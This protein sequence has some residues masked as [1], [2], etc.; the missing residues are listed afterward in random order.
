MDD[1]YCYHYYYY[2]YHHQHHKHQHQLIIN[3]LAPTRGHERGAHVRLPGPTAKRNPSRLKWA[4][5][6]D[7]VKRL[8]ANDHDEMASSSQ[9]E[10]EAK[11]KIIPEGRTISTRSQTTTVL[12]NRI[13]GPVESSKASPPSNEARQRRGDKLGL[14][15]EHNSPLAARAEPKRMMRLIRSAPSQLWLA[16]DEL[17]LLRL[18]TGTG[19]WPRDDEPESFGAPLGPLLAV[20]WGKSIPASLLFSLEAAENND[21]PLGALETGDDAAQDPRSGREWAWGAAR[22]HSKQDHYRTHPRDALAHSLHGVA[23]YGVTLDDGVLEPGHGDD[24]DDNRSGELE[25]L[26][27]YSEASEIIRSSGDGEGADKWAAARAARAREALKKEPMSIEDIGSGKHERAL[28]AARG[29]APS[30]LASL[31]LM[32]SILVA[33]QDPGSSA[34]SADLQPR[35]PAP[36]SSSAVATGGGWALPL[37]AN[38]VV[39]SDWRAPKDKPPEGELKFVDINERPQPAPDASSNGTTTGKSSGAT[40]PLSTRGSGES[41]TSASGALAAARS[42]SSAMLRHLEHYGDRRYGQWA[43]RRFGGAFRPES[44]APSNDNSNNHH[45]SRRRAFDDRFGNEMGA[46]ANN[47]LAT[48]TGARPARS[49]TL[50]RFPSWLRLVPGSIWNSIAGGGTVSADRHFQQQLQLQLAGGSTPA[51]RRQVALLGGGGGATTNSLFDR[52]RRRIGA[53]NSIRVHNAFR[54]FAWRLLASLSMPTPII[55]E[56][57]RQ[58]FYSPDD[59]LANDGLF[60][61][62]TSKTLRIGRTLYTSIFNN[63]N[64]NINNSFRNSSIFKVPSNDNNKRNNNTTTGTGRSGT[65]LAA[66]ALMPLVELFLLGYGP[67]HTN[68]A[69]KYLMATSSR[70]SPRALTATMGPNDVNNQMSSATNENRRYFYAADDDDDEERLVEKLI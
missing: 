51:R 27:F 32:M 39:S 67:N 6:V 5:V 48:A 40:S 11:T 34:A 26:A 8:P 55:Y 23:N 42:L 65:E 3:N 68:D 61:K 52:I 20:G 24:D 62:N 47:E 70:R 59:D 25:A 37:G 21:A 35:V 22:S 43:E 12:W 9:R 66:R 13:S 60:N 14:I 7:V 53:R 33:I 49:T 41:T 15:E 36:H 56:L 16:H 30:Q 28:M 2:Y 45:G 18:R 17:A 31:L 1:H 10:E 58:H 46:S 50:Q 29:A 44:A 63:K 4:L 69:T 19:C 38:A 64:N 54:D 57:R